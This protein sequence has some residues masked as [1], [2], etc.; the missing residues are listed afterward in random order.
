[1]THY[2]TLLSLFEKKDRIKIYMLLV[3]SLFGAVAETFSIGMVLPY[4]DII[5]SP[6]KAQNIPVLGSVFFGLSSNQIII[7]ASIGLFIAFLLKNIYLFLLSLYQGKF[8]F[9]RHVQ[10]SYKLL[11]SYLYKP[12]SF[13]FDRNVAEIQRNFSSSIANVMQSVFLSSLALFIELLVAVLIFLLLLFA[14]VTSTLVVAIVFG[15]VMYLFYQK[16]RKSIILYGKQQQDA[17]FEI[18]K[19]VNQGI[20]GIKEIKVRENYEFFLENMNKAGRQYAKAAIYN[21]IIGQA[22]RL[23]IEIIGIG[24]MSIIV[25]MNL[26]LGKDIMKLIPIL[27]LFALGA[28]RLMPS[29]SRLINYITIIRFN[30]TS[31]DNIHKDLK[32]S[33]DVALMRTKS[34]IRK[35]EYIDSIRIKNLNFKYDSGGKNILN[36]I[37]LTIKKGNKIGIIGESG[38]GKT[39]LLDCLL[40]LLQPNSGDI[41]IDEI[42]I[43]EN[44]SSWHKVISYIPQTIYLNDDSIINNICLGVNEK[45][46]DKEKVVDLLEKVKLKEFVLNLPNGLDSKIGDNG[47]CISGGQKQRIAIARAL[48]TDPD[49]I[50][51]DEATSALD[52]DTEMHIAEALNSLG[53]DKTFIIVSHRLNALITCDEVYKIEKGFMQKQCLS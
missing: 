16:Q 14:D 31:L 51:M 29:I 27:S 1:M 3:A 48:Y 7:T 34:E 18:L 25:L 10:I 21:N 37:N 44:L 32:D 28:Y 19:W 12:Y 33:S 46:V 24:A 13:F 43:Y 38:Q 39:T 53:K 40:G 5:M 49:I 36:D 17:A 8:T 11:K 4:V 2:K 47:I 15:G 23:V 35:I 6:T 52:S 42:S 45:Q 26:A 41:L 50:I 20:L 30:F 22:P 9:N